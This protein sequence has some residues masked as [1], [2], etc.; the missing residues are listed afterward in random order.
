M[1]QLYI[2]VRTFNHETGLFGPEI[3]KV[4]PVWLNQNFFDDRGSD[5][6]DVYCWEKYII[7]DITV[8]RLDHIVFAVRTVTIF[9]MKSLKQGK[10]RTF[11]EPFGL[12]I[13]KECHGMVW[14]GT[15]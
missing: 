4:V 2:I 1:D 8:R 5:V 7:V 9:D 14:Y 3:D 12:N 15:K 10:L 13:K 11:K 6:P